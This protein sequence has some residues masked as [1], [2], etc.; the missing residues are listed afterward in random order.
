LN[1]RIEKKKNYPFDITILNAYIRRMEKKCFKCKELKPLTE[2]YVH[3]RMADGRINKC[4]NCAKADARERE[5]ILSKD[6]DWVKSE[7]KRH[8]EKYYRLDYKGKNK[9]NYESQRMYN[10]TH[11]EKYPEKIMAQ[12]SSQRIKSINGNNHH[13]SYNEEHYKDVIDLTKKDHLKA[14]RFIIYD[15]ERLMYRDLNGILLDTKEKHQKYIFD[16]ILNEED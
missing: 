2:Y 9:P 16:K 15:Q 3:K 14:H 1:F 7:R 10:L 12:I 5:K 11:K 4:K 8:R 13:W 6:D